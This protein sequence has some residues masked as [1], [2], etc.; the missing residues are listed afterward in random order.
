MATSR[1]EKKAWTVITPAGNLYCDYA[2]EAYEYK[3]TYGY[4]VVRTKDNE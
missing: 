1:T 4:I 3:N 2:S